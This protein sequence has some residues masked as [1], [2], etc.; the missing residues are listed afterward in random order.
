MGAMA[1][2]IPASRY[3]EITL[4]VHPCNF[5]MRKMSEKY[6]KSNFMKISQ[7]VLKFQLKT[8]Y[9]ITIKNNKKRGN[10]LFL[11]HDRNFSS[12]LT[13]RDLV[14]HERAADIFVIS[15]SM[16]ESIITMAII[17]LKLIKDD[18]ERYEK[19]QYV[20]IYKTYNHLKNLG[21]EYLSG[22]PTSE[23]QNI[24]L[25]RDNYISKY[26][27]QLS[28]WTGKSLLDNVKL[29]DKN[30]EPSCN[31]KHFYEYLYCQVY[32]KGSQTV[33]SSFAGIKKGIVE[34]QVI[35]PGF[36]PMMRLKSDENHLIFSYIHCL[37]TFL[38]SIRFMGHFLNNST[39]EKYYHKMTGYII[40]KD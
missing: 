31:E 20:E 32:R 4:L 22:V 1:L 7:E 39:T 5:L 3:A 17:S 13:I 33:H 28:S 19:F 25:K 34:E 2:R 36:P 40:S 9:P 37:I 6:T 27:N 29:L 24:K 21:L 15:R 35:I 30:I 14:E 16:F 38:S 8:L 10:I 12:F 18:L 26:G 11:H 23:F